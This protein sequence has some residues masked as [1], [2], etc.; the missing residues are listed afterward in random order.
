MVIDDVRLLHERLDYPPLAGLLSM[1]G[2]DGAQDVPIQDD[3][4]RLTP[5]PRMLSTQKLTKDEPDHG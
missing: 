5:R 2:Q 3:S 4:L 1:I